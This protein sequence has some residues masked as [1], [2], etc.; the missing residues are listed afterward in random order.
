MNKN[1]NDINHLNEK[2]NKLQDVEAL[3]INFI[4]QIIMEK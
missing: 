1:N 4:F 2:K 3:K